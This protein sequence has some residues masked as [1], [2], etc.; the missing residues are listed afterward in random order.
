MGFKQQVLLTGL[1]PWSQYHKLP[2]SILSTFG[3]ILT[4]IL[5]LQIRSILCIL[6]WLSI[7]PAIFVMGLLFVNSLLPLMP[8]CPGWHHHQKT[9]IYD[10]H[11]SCQCFSRSSK[12]ISSFNLHFKAQKKLSVSRTNL[13]SPQVISN[14][15]SAVCVYVCMY[16]SIYLSIFLEI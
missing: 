14:S 4:V 7:P 1:L 10:I 6:P 9:L 8:V 15:L 3:K 2:L 16:L 5:G 13:F 12:S 11:I